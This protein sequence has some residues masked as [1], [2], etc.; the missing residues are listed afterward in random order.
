MVGARFQATL[1]LHQKKTTAGA[2]VNPYARLGRFAFAKPWLEKSALNLNK[3][4]Q[5][6]GTHRRAARFSYSLRGFTC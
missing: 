2:T 1:E 6:Y 3:S 4:Q 5:A